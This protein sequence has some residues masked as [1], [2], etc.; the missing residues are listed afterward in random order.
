MCDDKK[1][2]AHKHPHIGSAKA[3]LLDIGHA[4]ILR[5]EP[6][7]VFNARMREQTDQQSQPGKYKDKP[8]Y[9]LIKR[10]R[11]TELFT[12]QDAYNLGWK[13]YRV[14]RHNAPSSLLDTYTQERLPIGKYPF[15]TT[16]RPRLSDSASINTAERTPSSS[17]E[18]A[19]GVVNR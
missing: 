1:H 18:G 5:Q 6:P 19:K 10:L 17:T 16:V 8:P 7:S 13:V 15:R 2:Y 14:L 9:M 4:H 3:Q 12:V 11:H